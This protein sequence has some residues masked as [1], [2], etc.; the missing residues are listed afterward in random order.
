MAGSICCWATKARATLRQLQRGGPLWPARIPISA[1]S[2]V[3]RKV[4]PRAARAGKPARS[5]AP[6]TKLRDERIDM[7]ADQPTDSADEGQVSQGPS[8]F[9]QLE[10]S[11]GGADAVPDSP[12]NVPADNIGEHT[13]DD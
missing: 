11:G 8:G 13:T 1:S 12:D 9:D 10:T 6:G 3:V 2:G 5:T 4:T 7:T